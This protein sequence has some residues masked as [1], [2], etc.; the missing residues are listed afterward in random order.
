VNPSRE[1]KVAIDVVGF[2]EDFVLEEEK[3]RMQELE[4]E[5]RQ[6]REL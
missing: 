1:T 3:A 5:V 4:D 2:Y 6:I